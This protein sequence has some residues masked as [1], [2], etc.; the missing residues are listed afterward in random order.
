M[1]RKC[2]IPH[3]IWERVYSTTYVWAPLNY[4][5]ALQNHEGLLGLK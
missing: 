4:I 2:D 5:N 1:G 3:Q